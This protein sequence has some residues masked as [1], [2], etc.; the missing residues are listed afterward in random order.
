[1][2]GHATYAGKDSPIT[3]AFGLGLHGE[4]TE[5]EVEALEEF[6]FSRGVPVYIEL[7]PLVDISLLNSLMNRGYR[8]LETGNV[9]YQELNAAN[10]SPILQA[11]VR[12][13]SAQEEESWTRAITLGFIETDV[14]DPMLLKVAKT[15]FH[16]EDS[17]PFLVKIEGQPAGGGGLFIKDGIADCYAQATIPAFRRRGV[18]TALLQA[19]LAYAAAQGCEIVMGTTMCGTTS[20]HNFERQGFRIAYTRL[21]LWREYRPT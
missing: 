12:I 16:T 20:Q 17:I 7:C 15:M 19:S 13:P 6:Y 2:G 18:Q 11:T 5:A 4:A 10:A 3:Q 8:I 1:M 14:P 21:K 9:L